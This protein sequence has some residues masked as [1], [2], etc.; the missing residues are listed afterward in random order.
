[1]A[2]SGPVV[3]SA[4]VQMGPILY[5]PSE[6]PLA[7]REGKQKEKKCTV[8]IHTWRMYMYTYVCDVN[9]QLHNAGS[10]VHLV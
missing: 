2:A 4:V 9:V 6:T 7:V 8:I 5:R 3:G 1:M 10:T